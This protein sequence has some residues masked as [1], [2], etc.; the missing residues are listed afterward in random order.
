M[1][2][3]GFELAR[4][5]VAQWRRSRFGVLFNESSERNGESPVG[6]PLS[7]S[8]YRGVV[9]RDDQVGQVQSEDVS[10]YRVVRPGQLAANVMWLNRS[11]LG[12]S[13]H[14][15]YVSPAYKVFCI[16]GAV[17]PGF[18][19]YVLRSSVYRA[20]FESVGRGVRPNA[21]MVDSSDLK[22]MPF[23]LPPLAEQQAIADYLDRETAQIDTLIEKQQRLVE[24]LRER[25]QGVLAI[26][27]DVNAPRTAI[28][29]VLSAIKDGTHGTFPRTSADE[30]RP[31][32]GARNVMDGRIV[33]DGQESFISHEDAESIVANGFPARGD[34][35]LVCVGATIGKAAVYDLPESH[36]FQR[37]VA[38]LRPGNA[39]DPSFLRY[40]IQSSMFQDELW[41]RAK[42]SAQPG[43]YMGDIVGIPVA[44]PPLDE[45]RR[46]AAY[47]DEQTAKIDT[48]LA[49]TE[50]FIELSRE[51]RSALIT[52]AV[53]GQIDVRDKVA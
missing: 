6:S 2:A 52:A 15:G 3:G 37:S 14:L 4:E 36:A 23:P 41:L 50:R 42:T 24:V 35:L 19:D 5:F 48:L 18:A 22:A 53:T 21:Q 1:T 16:S 27:S 25:R 32:L 26:A 7:V 17:V 13:G 8:E 11:G 44:V 10:M 40:Q 38:F 28:G 20:F 47:L 43:I 45:Q 46:I 31:L 30:G 29:H 49:K 51:R 34:V 39:I 9:P 12:V 33:I